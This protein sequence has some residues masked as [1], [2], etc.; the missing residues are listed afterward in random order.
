MGHLDDFLHDAEIE[1]GWSIL[2]L[3]EFTASHFSDRFKSSVGHRVFFT[4]PTEG[5]RACC[6]VIHA[7]LAHRVLPG[8]IRLRDRGVAV[9]LHWEGWNL[10]L[11]SA[12]LYPHDSLEQYLHSLDQLEELC[13][14]DSLSDSFISSK[15]AGMEILSTPVYRIAGVD[16]QSPVG[17]PTSKAEE[18]VV[19]TATQGDRKKKGT[20]FIKF[21]MEHDLRLASTFSS[22]LGEYWTCHHYF[23][24]NP[25]QIDYTVTDLPSRACRD[26]GVRDCTATTTDHRPVFLE[27]FG[28][29]VQ[30]KKR[31]VPHSS[32][33]PIGWMCRD[34][35]F[36]NLLRAEH[37]WEQTGEANLDEWSNV[38]LY[39]DGSFASTRN[40]K[41][42]Y[43]GW[44]FA[45]FD[46]SS[47]R[48]LD[49][50]IFL[51]MVQSLSNK[52]TRCFL[53]HPDFRTTPGRFRQS[54]K[55]F[56]GSSW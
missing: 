8:T 35:N 46:V 18:R 38:C 47:P 40:R 15:F 26:A 48:T 42:Q 6:I 11:V 52:Q 44:G 20:H 14:L 21:C 7:S 29:W 37:G 13:L 12:H 22:L 51:R 32:P 9:C 50:A 4:A 41:K 33:P 56:C 24:T 1:L 16:A 55:H 30:P 23:K 5:C 39:T 2:L 34:N 53:G 3:Q 28:R 10:L 25:S 43:A 49:R 17:R 36:C 31:F 45:I 19:G 27:V 54:W